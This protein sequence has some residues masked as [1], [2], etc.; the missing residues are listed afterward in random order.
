VGIDFAA[1]SAEFDLLSAEFATWTTD[2]TDVQTAVTDETAARIAADLAFT[3]RA[4]NE[5]VTGSWTF[6]NNVTLGTD[7]GLVLDE[8]SSAPATPAAGKAILYVK[9]DGKVYS[10]DDAGV[11]TEYVSVANFAEAVDDRVAALFVPGN[12]IDVTYNDV[13]NT[14]TID[15]EGLTS[16]DISDWAEAV[17][18][19]VNSLLVAGSNITLTY[20]DVANTLTVA[21]TGGAGVRW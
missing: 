5:T 2:F 4:A 15:V 12:N 14:F 21:S 1:L 18:D 3:V 7:A 11:E 8:H 10:K 16:A 9:A 20:N 13:S 6:A 17:D 19:R